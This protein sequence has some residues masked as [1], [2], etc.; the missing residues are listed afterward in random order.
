MSELKTNHS[1]HAEPIMALLGYRTYQLVC[2]CGEVKAV[3]TVNWIDGVLHITAVDDAYTVEIR[4]W[5]PVGRWKT[6]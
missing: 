5:G 6:E 1:L 2:E 3:L 4:R